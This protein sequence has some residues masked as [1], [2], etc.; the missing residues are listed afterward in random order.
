[1]FQQLFLEFIAGDLGVVRSFRLFRPLQGQGSMQEH[2]SQQGLP[3]CEDDIV[4]VAWT[5]NQVSQVSR[6]YLV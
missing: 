4:L 5:L 3:T 2:Y 6:Y 1:M